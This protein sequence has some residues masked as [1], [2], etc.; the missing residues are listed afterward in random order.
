MRDGSVGLLDVAGQ[1][2][3]RPLESDV[4]TIR[5]IKMDKK[6]FEAYMARF[7]ED[8]A[9]D[10]SRTYEIDIESARESAASQTRERLSEGLDTPGCYIY[11]IELE[12]DSGTTHIG[13]IE[14]SVP[15]GEDWAWLELEVSFS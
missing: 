13:Y 6:G 14:F 12:T 2:W 4:S 15:E 9:Q 3:A 7:V 1:L 11:N 5:L 8:Y 10:M